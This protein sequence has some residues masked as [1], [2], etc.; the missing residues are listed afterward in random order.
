MRQ[1]YYIYVCLAALLV[2]GNFNTSWGYTAEGE[3]YKHLTFHFA[4][5]SVW[6]LACNVLC[7]YILTRHR[8]TWAE[9]GSSFAI[10]TLSS[11]IA[12]HALPTVGLSGAIYALFGMRLARCSNLSRSS[13]VKFALF[14]LLPSLTGKVNVLLH[15]LCVGVGYLLIFSK[16]QLKRIQADAK[17][18]HR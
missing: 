16:D 17:R 18:C 8:I 7:L 10:A 12:P 15:L 11:L 2:L 1:R 6:H 5:A 4:H 14:L 3:L 9:M 13:L